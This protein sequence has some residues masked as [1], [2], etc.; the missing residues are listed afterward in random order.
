MLS[1]TVDVHYDNYSTRPMAKTQSPF[2][3]SFTPEI[4]GIKPRSHPSSYL[5][6]F[7]D[8]S[9]TSSRATTPINGGDRNSRQIRSSN[10]G[11][12]LISSGNIGMGKSL[13][14]IHRRNEAQKRL[15]KT[16]PWLREKWRAEAKPSP[17]RV[18]TGSVDYN[19]LLGDQLADQIIQAESSRAYN[20]MLK[21]HFQNQANFIAKLNG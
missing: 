4:L 19:R 7:F 16:A 21:A 10:S 8:Q 3:R 12:N 13:R 15:A 2:F 11:N 17:V 18:L 5:P 6:K 9:L 20:S 1:I 14:A